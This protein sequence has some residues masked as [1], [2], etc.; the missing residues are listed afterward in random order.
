[1]ILASPGWF[2]KGKNKLFTMQLHLPKQLWLAGPGPASVDCAAPSFRQ[3][4]V[5]VNISG[6]CI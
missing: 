5:Q 2:E 1:M 4:R 6:G 3:V